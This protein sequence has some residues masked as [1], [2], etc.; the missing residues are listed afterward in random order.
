MTCNP[1]AR[2]LS[3]HVSSKILVI[4][5]YESSTFI[6]MLGNLS[7]ENLKKP[8]EEVLEPFEIVLNWQ[9]VWE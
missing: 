8:W 2:Y 4:E 7:I 9:C 1:G 6:K 3:G 5:Y